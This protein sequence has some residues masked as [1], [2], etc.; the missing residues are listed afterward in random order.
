M[1]TASLVGCYLDGCLYSQAQITNCQDDQAWGSRCRQLN[2]MLSM[3][4]MGIIMRKMVWM[5]GRFLRA[6]P[7]EVAPGPHLLARLGRASPRRLANCLTN[8][9]SVSSNKEAALKDWCYWHSC[10]PSQMH[11]AIAV[12]SFLLLH[13]NPTE[14]AI[15]RRLL[16]LKVN[17][18]HTN[19]PTA[20]LQQHTDL[21]ALH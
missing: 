7:E 3:L 1:R 4:S 2:C 20:K 15:F 10:N 21:G 17:Q 18:E 16:L 9:I 14:C 19:T 13:T 12:E 8:F 6:N 5:V 11:I